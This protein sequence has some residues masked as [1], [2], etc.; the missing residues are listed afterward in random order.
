MEGAAAMLLLIHARFVGA[1][2]QDSDLIP[3]SDC[4]LALKHFAS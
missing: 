4:G 1:V 2:Q 3:T